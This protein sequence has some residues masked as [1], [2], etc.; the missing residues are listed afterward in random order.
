MAPSS[1]PV[2]AQERWYT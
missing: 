1:Y 2:L